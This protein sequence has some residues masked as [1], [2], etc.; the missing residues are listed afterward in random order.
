MQYYNRRRSGDKQRT[1][2]LVPKVT[3]QVI[4]PKEEVRSEV[5]KKQKTETSKL[6]YFIVERNR[7]FTVNKNL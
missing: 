4:K 7:G 1:L 6:I 5:S 2:P 3:I